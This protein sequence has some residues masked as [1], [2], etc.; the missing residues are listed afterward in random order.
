[1]RNLARAACS[2]SSWAFA[3]QNGTRAATT[4]VSTRSWASCSALAA[5]FQPS[6]EKPTMAI[7]AA[8]DAIPQTAGLIQTGI[9]IGFSFHAVRGR[10]SSHRQVQYSLDGEPPVRYRTHPEINPG[11]RIGYDEHVPPGQSHLATLRLFTVSFPRKRNPGLQSQCC[12]PGFPLFAGMTIFNA[13]A[14]LS[15]RYALRSA[16]EGRYRAVFRECVIG[17]SLTSG[18]VPSRNLSCNA[19]AP[20]SRGQANTKA[21]V[22]AAGMNLRRRAPEHISSCH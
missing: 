7:M 10:I 20:L 22:F 18:D 12:R 11:E 3:T 15:L 4:A 5:V 16:A 8:P 1:M 19:F 13:I 17:A 6:C 21:P 9:C 14:L 2:V